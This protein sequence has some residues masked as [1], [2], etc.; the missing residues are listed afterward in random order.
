MNCPNCNADLKDGAKFCQS[1]G[2][3]IAQQEPVS[4]F[5]QSEQ[6]VQPYDY[7]PQQYEQPVQQYADQPQQYGQYGTQT[8]TVPAPKKSPVKAI[9]IAAIAVVVIA[10]I[11]LGSFFIFKS[12]NDAS[13]GSYKDAVTDI[14]NMFNEGK[15]L[16][17]MEKYSV[18]GKAPDV[19]GMES[20]FSLLNGIKWEIEI[21]EAKTPVYKKGIDDE[22]DEYI[23]YVTG[24]ETY[25]AKATEVALVKA[26]VSM[27]GSMIGQPLNE[28]YDTTIYMARIDGA[29][30]CDAADDVF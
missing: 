19:N 8:M 24:D 12:C 14:V 17:A 2:A 25:Q 7:Q 27:K 22:F 9:V 6:P 29:W 13:K 18:D 10:G 5:S 30:K 16:E 15:Y 23:S 20:A 21:D 1:C 3:P 26:K 11:A 4:D 28:S